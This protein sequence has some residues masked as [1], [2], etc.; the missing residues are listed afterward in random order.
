MS[1]TTHD[2]TKLTARVII[3]L[4]PT[5]Q[6][7]M[8]YY[9]NGQR[10]RTTLDRGNEWWQVVDQLH[11]QAK[12]IQSAEERKALREDEA[13]RKRHRGV[14]IQTAEDFGIGFAK[15]VI[16]GPVPMGYGQYF[17]KAETKPAK[18]AKPGISGEEME[19]LL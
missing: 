8:E 16:K 1:K 13:S 12:A 11:M 14:W 18:L 3:E 10:T 6:L 4:G 7:H 5:G 17:A 9:T 15:R 19:Q 2:A